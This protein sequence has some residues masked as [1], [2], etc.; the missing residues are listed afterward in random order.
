M[1]ILNEQYRNLRIDLKCIQNNTSYIYGTP[2]K[3][4]SFYERIGKGS[5]GEV[6]VAYNSSKNEKIAVK[7]FPINISS[8]KNEIYHNLNHTNILCPFDFQ[9]DQKYNYLLM[10]YYEEDLLEILQ[11]RNLKEND[12]IH[13]ITQIFLGIQHCH[14]Q[15]IYHLDIKP[16]NILVDEYGKVKITDF[17]NSLNLNISNHTKY[18]WGTKIYLSPEVLKQQTNLDYAAIDIWALGITFFVM[19]FKKYPIFEDT[20][21][22]KFD[23]DV[24][25][26]LNT[27]SYSLKILLEGM[28]CFDHHQR[29]TINQCLNSEYLIKFYFSN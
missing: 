5:D 1:G 25:M 8:Q 4:Y 24:Y 28:L 19:I 10:K 29:F 15:N 14:Q 17:Q 12:I 23:D 20:K 21:F 7:V 3:K 13:Y 27:L 9:K 18:N 2:D 11:N 16:E 22:D 26:C 6:Y